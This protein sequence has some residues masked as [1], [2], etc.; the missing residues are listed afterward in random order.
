MN[1]LICYHIFVL[2]M[3]VLIGYHIT[4]RH[5]DVLI[6]YYITIL[7]MNVLIGY[8]ITVLHVLIGYRQI[9]IQM[10]IQLPPV[11]NLNTQLEEGGY[12]VY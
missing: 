3:S 10:M 11:R 9:Q 5:M 1:V 12:L 8:Y 7:H 4:I 2:H 6:G